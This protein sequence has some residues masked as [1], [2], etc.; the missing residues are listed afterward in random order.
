MRRW[1]VALWLVVL[2]AA[3]VV[4]FAAVWRIF[5]GTEHGQVLDTIAL[6][7]NR[8][9]RRRVEG[10]VG[11]VLNTISVVSLLV[12][13]GV[14]GFIALIRGRVA[15]ALLA[16]ALIVGSNV[17]TQL[18]K[19]GITR[20]DFGVDPEREAV[21]NSLPSGHTVVAASVAV[22][23]VFVLP[24]RARGLGGILGAG[25]AALAGVGTL[26]AG[27]HRP[28]DAVAAL[29]VV[30]GWACAAGVV[31]MLVQRQRQRADEVRSHWVAVTVL[32]LAGLAL[33]LV[34]ALAL[35]WTNQVWSTTPVDELSR[36]RLFA[37]YAGGAAGI[38]ATASLVMAGVLA[39]VHRVV[40]SA[41]PQT[42][43]V[44]PAYETAA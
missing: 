20:P 37:A 32:A 33:L 44:Q 39:T 16:M 30:G 7:G 38:A 9:G 14:V 19:L 36:R 40:P 21:G 15:V 41:A 25:F 1:P 4:A 17:T 5:V 26:S 13:I 3:Y 22:A 34:A 29:L 24:Y 10:V 42:P 8:I 18:L 35:R 27:W 43:D 6:T 31:L 12:A 2:G 23:L 11:T 28:S